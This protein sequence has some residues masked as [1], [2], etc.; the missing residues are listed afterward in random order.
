MLDENKKF[1][2]VYVLLVVITI[3]NIFE[4]KFLTN[5]TALLGQP[6]GYPSSDS[7]TLRQ[8][9]GY[10]S[11]DDPTLRQPGGYH[12][13]WVKLAASGAQQKMN[14]ENPDLDI[15]KCKAAYL[16]YYSRQSDEEAQNALLTI[17]DC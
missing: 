7:S 6:G 2:I 11:S 9:G 16:A 1:I 8:S 10:P 3:L 13:G 12:Y 4:F 15:E 17:H 5:N 14:T